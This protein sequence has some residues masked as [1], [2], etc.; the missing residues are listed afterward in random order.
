M[1]I[2]YVDSYYNNSQHCL[3][4][5][6]VSA[7][8]IFSTNILF[9]LTKGPQEK[10][11]KAKMLLWTQLWGLENGGNS[12]RVLSFEFITSFIQRNST[13][14]TF[15]DIIEDPIETETLLQFSTGPVSVQHLAC[16][17]CSHWLQWAQLATTQLGQKKSATLHSLQTKLQPQHQLS[18]YIH[19]YVCYALSWVWSIK[20]E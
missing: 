19:R 15:T 11:D 14:V 18:T 6:F 9:A 12:Y 16:N 7:T 1:Y 4:R 17:A 20:I 5:N 8:M 13:M 3:L 10:L 2:V